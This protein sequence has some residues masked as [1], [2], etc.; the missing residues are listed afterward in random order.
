MRIQL[1]RSIL[2]AGEDTEKDS[3]WDVPRVLALDLIAQ[4]SA[5]R[6]GV[7]RS[8]FLWASGVDVKPLRI[9]DAKPQSHFPQGGS[10]S[11]EEKA[12]EVLQRAEK[13]GIRLTFE[14]GLIFAEPP[15]EAESEVIAMVTEQVVKYLPEVHPI[16]SRRNTGVR[17]KDFVGQRIWSHEFGEGKLESAEPNGE[18]VITVNQDG[19]RSSRMFTVRGSDILIL[20]DKETNAAAASSSPEPLRPA[21][22]WKS[23]LQWLRRSQDT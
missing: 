19:W 15:A 1:K 4:E 12:T 21:K 22:P 20:L 5:V 2:L 17:A 14:S 11:R 23:I 6:C 10:V 7:W 13:L 18:L 16:L 3:I 9:A 8:I